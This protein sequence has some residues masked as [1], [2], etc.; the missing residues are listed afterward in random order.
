MLYRVIIFLLLNFAALGIGSFFTTSGVSSAWYTNLTKSPWTPPG[1]V[2]GAAWTTIMI[3]FAFY[4]AYAWDTLANRNLLIGLFIAQW[5][6]NIL[7]NPV[8]FKYHEVFFGLIVISALTL[9][10]GFI[11]ATNWHQL[12]MKSL[13]ILPYF[14]WLLIATYLNAYILLKN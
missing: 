10:V 11:L 13:L 14:M 9:L 6:L 2:F 3:C 8:F 4:M 5:V 7:W 12:K 1:W